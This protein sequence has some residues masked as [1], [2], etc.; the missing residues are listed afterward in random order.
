MVWNPVSC[1]RCLLSGI[2]R[3]TYLCS[4]T[5][6]I[7]VKSWCE[8]GHFP[9][10]FSNARSICRTLNLSSRSTERFYMK[11]YEALSVWVLSSLSLL[12]FFT[13][14]L[15]FSL[16]PQGLGPAPDLL[17]DH[18]HLSTFFYFLDTPCLLIQFINGT[19]GQFNY[20]FAGFLP[21]NNLLIT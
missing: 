21:A 2:P 10:D 9:L 18:A 7:I 17:Q 8:I 14:C 3:F 15:P 20:I 13:V 6:F 1:L 11:K 16:Q 12:V 19:A 5:S 4:L